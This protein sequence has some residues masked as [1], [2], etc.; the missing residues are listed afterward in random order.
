MIIMGCFVYLVGRIHQ[1]DFKVFVGGVLCNPVGVED[2][3]TTTTTTNTLLNN[4]YML[5]DLP[6]EL[7]DIPIEEGLL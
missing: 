1:D 2:T 5:E 4:N 6:T 3:E 7:N